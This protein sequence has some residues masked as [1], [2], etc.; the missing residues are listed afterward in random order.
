MSRFYFITSVLKS[1]DFIIYYW[2]KNLNLKNFVLFDE[3]EL[4]CIVEF[5]TL[6]QNFIMIKDMLK[7]RT[8]TWLL[9]VDIAG[10][11]R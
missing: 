6:L 3:V 1:V 5:E 2:V 11:H 8:R 9:F 10:V 4:L 7:G